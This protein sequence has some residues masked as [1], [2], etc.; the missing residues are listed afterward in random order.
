MTQFLNFHTHNFPAYPNEKS[1]YNLL[2]QD[3]EAYVK[4]GDSWVS[5]GI[6]PWY[7]DLENWEDQV[8]KVKN[9]VDNEQVLAVGECGL[10]RRIAF[11]LDQ[12]LLIFDAQV[13]VAEHIQKP[14]IIHCVS[15]FNELLRWKKETKPTVPLI[16]HGFNNKQEMAQQLLAHGFYFSLGTALLNSN[17]NASKVLKM[18]PKERLFLEN[19]DRTIPVKMVY[20]A[21]AVQLEM[22]IFELKSQ[23]WTNF[24][25]VFKK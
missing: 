25:R 17:S 1:I 7:A 3:I 9:L 2:T 23:I 18:L 24:V 16:V 14:V 10:D 22:T 8:Q 12:Q 21:A 4:L 15:A 20:E 11:P 13:K 6:H 5:V 19:D